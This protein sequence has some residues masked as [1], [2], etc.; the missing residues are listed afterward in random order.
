MVPARLVERAMATQ[1]R[2]RSTVQTRW[3]V[4]LTLS[5]NETSKV[6][7]SITS[8]LNEIPTERLHGGCPEPKWH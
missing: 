7:K 2:Q 1:V 6:S 4:L 8:T 5:L 3:P